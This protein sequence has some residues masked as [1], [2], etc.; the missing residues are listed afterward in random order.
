MNFKLSGQIDLVTAGELLID[1]ISTEYSD[2]LKSAGNF[3]KYAG[4]SPGNIACNVAAQ[5]YKVNMISNVGNDGFGKYLIEN[6]KRYNVNTKYVK[7]DEKNNTSIVCVTKS[8]GNPEFIAYR[9]ADKELNISGSELEMI[10]EAK[11]FHVSSFAL[12]KNPARDNLL[13]AVRFAKKNNKLVGIDPNFREVMWD[14][15]EYGIEF[16]KKVIGYADVIKPS[17]DDAYH[18][19]GKM[20]I[21][22][23]L[24]SFY[25]MGPKLV[26]MT[27]G[28][29]GYVYYD[30]EK[31]VYG[32][33]EADK[34]T[35]VTGAGDAFWAGFYCGIL[36]D[37]SCEDSIK[38]GNRFSAYNI[39]ETGA[40]VKLPDCKNWI[41]S[42]A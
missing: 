26:I 27:L 19:L 1:M 31:I 6:L 21:D 29:D 14:D 30:G 20:E 33:S 32:K 36:S 38:I 39:K 22:E 4:G 40:V 42:E 35:D 25:E 17:E 12:S 34:V 13:K 8:V 7:Q 15:R 16:M 10:K 37:L 11:I 3:S 2:G 28:K 18:I 23:Y 24:K 41:K 5:G 9:F